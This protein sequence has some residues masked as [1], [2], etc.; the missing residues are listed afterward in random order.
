MKKTSGNSIALQ[1]FI[2]N[3]HLSLTETCYQL[4]MKTLI[5]W[6][7]KGAKKFAEGETDGQ[8]TLKKS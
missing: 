3:K 1:L 5:N 2:T 6:L 7:I 8:V 4:I